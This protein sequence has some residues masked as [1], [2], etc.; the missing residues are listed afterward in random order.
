MTTIFYGAVVTPISHSSYDALPHALLCVD[1][2]TGDIHWVEP[3]VPASSLQDV[4]AEHGI[5]DMV[6][7]EFVELRDGE[8]LVPGFVDTHTVR[9]SL[10]CAAESCASSQ[11]R[12]L[13]NVQI[14]SMHHSFRILEGE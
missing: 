14:Y 10:I 3:D 9:E 5:V 8:F 6:D 4:L 7:V 12:E 11:Y 2:K 13:T 1:R